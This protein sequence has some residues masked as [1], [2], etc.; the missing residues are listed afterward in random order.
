MKLPITVVP[1]NRGF[2]L[3]S[4]DAQIVAHVL[5]HPGCDKVAKAIAAKLNRDGLF[6]RQPYEYTRQ[7]WLEQRAN[8]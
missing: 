4:S 6:G 2:D 3:V 5:D 7:D 8:G 1:N